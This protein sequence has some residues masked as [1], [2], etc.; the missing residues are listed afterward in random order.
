MMIDETPQVSK[1]VDSSAQNQGV[2]ATFRAA[3][4]ETAQGRLVFASG[5]SNVRISAHSQ[6]DELYHARFE[7]H[8]PSV[9]VED[10]IITIHYRRYLLFDWLV[11]R[12][13]PWATV[14]L[15]TTIPWEIEF[16]DGLSH[17]N[18]DLRD[19][20]LRSLDMG[21]VSNAR[22]TLPVP[23][24]E[25]NIYFSGSASDITLRRPAEVGVRLQIAGAASSLS[26]DGQRMGATG[27]GIRWQSDNYTSATNRYEIGIAGS[28]SNITIGVL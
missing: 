6:V 10:G 24:G 23:A 5:A 12:R 1:T 8:L 26:L 21:S 9:R 18:A 28:V 13:Q 2:S 15:N 20:Q 14:A 22:L 3:L 11:Y 7:E 4:G 17:L 27:S 25:A 16:R 19:V